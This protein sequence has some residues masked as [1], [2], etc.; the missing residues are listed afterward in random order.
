MYYRNKKRLGRIV[1]GIV[2]VFAVLGSLGSVNGYILSQQKEIQLDEL[3]QQKKLYE[4]ELYVAIRDLRAGQ[5]LTWE[6]VVLRVRYTDTEKSDYLDTEDIGKMLATDV[7]EGECLTKRMLTDTQTD[8]R[9]VV[10]SRIDLPIGLTEGD[11]VDLRISFGNAEDYVVLAKKYLIYCEEKKGIILRMREEEILFLS[12]ALHDCENYKDTQ[13]YLVKY[14]E[15]REVQESDVNYIPN[16]A[17]L[18]MLQQDTKI[19]VRRQL[20]QRLTN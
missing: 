10:I 20:E 9:E 1:Q 14:P 6:D 19:Q 2:I 12:S 18:R 8:V 17:V 7:R 11:L 15:Y 4:K 16:E 3:K 5:V 13:L